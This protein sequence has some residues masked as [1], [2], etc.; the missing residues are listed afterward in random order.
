MNTSDLPLE[1]CDYIYDGI[2][3]YI[4]R[5]STKYSLISNYIK[6]DIDR[7]RN[8]S[9]YNNYKLCEY[10]IDIK[11]KYTNVVYILSET[12]NTNML[13]KLYAKR[14]TKNTFVYNLFV[15]CNINFVKWCIKK[16]MLDNDEIFR[17]YRVYVY[18]TDKH[19]NLN[20]LKWL[21]KNVADNKYF[22][23]QIRYWDMDLIIKKN[24]YEML[25]WFVSI[26]HKFNKY[27]YAIANGY[28]LKNDSAK[29]IINQYNTIQMQIQISLCAIQQK[30]IY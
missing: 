30:L 17:C 4:N 12:Q 15:F 20:I 22:I 23:S 26:G 28:I 1:L 7:F 11:M 21:C 6:N 16:Y 29:F 13:K 3:H 24:Y 8:I 25:K 27:E 2:Y 5:M 9:F 10:H 18:Y 14:I 19:A